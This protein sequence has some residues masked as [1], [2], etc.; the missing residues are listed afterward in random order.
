M[1]FSSKISH[2]VLTYLEDQGQ[3]LT[4][5]IDVLGSHF[6]LMRDP[7]CWVPA[8]E[9]EFFLEK[10]VQVFGSRESELLRRVG[11]RQAQLHAWGVLDSVLKMMTKPQE[12]FRQPQ[13]F[14]SYFV[15][16]EPPLEN[17]LRTE[18]GIH[19][20]WPLPSD[21][22]PHVTEYMKAAFEALPTYMGQGLAV[23]R[24]EDI[25]LELKWPVKS[26]LL[27]QEEA[28]RQIS[29][30]LLQNVVEELQRSQRDLEEK[31]RELQ[32]KNEELLQYTLHMKEALPAATAPR[33]Q[34]LSRD[35]DVPGHK[36]GQNIARLHD[37]LVRAQQLIT[38]ILSENKANASVREAMRRMDWDYVKAQYP[39]TVSES[40]E[41]LRQLQ[42]KYRHMQTSP[43]KEPPHV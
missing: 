6:E 8:P 11:H 20:D 35:P 5:F 19:F 21:Q 31:N 3:D 24:W 41:S 22:Y 7:A 2:S 37:Y 15:S 10:M 13:R 39:R 38:M 43:E 27:F 32:R 1:H 33:F 16:P 29:P 26:S 28:G 40:V 30:Q 14:M 4:G 36:L 12:I 9:M 34:D 23:C 25:R 17:V 18:E 42:S